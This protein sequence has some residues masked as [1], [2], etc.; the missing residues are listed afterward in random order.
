MGRAFDWLGN[1]IQG[2]PAINKPFSVSVPVSVPKASVSV[3]KGNL[4]MDE[5]RELARSVQRDA[6]AARAAYRDSGL[7]K[8]ARWN[9]RNRDRLR[10]YQ[11]SYM[12]AY[13]DKPTPNEA[14]AL[15]L[16]EGPNEQGKPNE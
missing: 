5:A 2:T 16:I 3:P 14:K 15:Q 4:T 10:E 12:R 7:T 11:R 1:M 13:R 9:R 6:D 8:Q